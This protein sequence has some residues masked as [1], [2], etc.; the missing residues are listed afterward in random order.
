MAGEYRCYF[1]L[2]AGGARTPAQWAPVFVKMRLQP[3]TSA[4]VAY[5]ITHNQSMCGLHY[6]FDINA[7]P[8]YALCKF[9]LNAG[10]VTAAQ[11]LINAQCAT[12]G[13][14]QPD[15]S[16]RVQALLLAEM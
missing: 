10:D 6:R 3:I 9:E 12:R 4:I 8:R 7:S 11:A 1:V 13:I 15:Y 14:V 16:S 2:D 5:G